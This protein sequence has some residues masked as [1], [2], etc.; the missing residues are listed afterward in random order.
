MYINF[1]ILWYIPINMVNEA[2]V[3]IYKVGNR[4]SMNLPSALVTD[5]LFPFV[6]NESLKIKVEG[7]KLIVTKA[8]N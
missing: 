4:H 3:K 6:P 2:D 8:R 5:S 1:N 7:K